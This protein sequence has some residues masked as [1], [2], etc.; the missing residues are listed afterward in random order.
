MSMEQFEQKKAFV[1]RELSRCVTAV[2]GNVSKLEYQFTDD[3]QESVI[4]RFSNG[5]IKTVDVTGDSLYSVMF[6]VVEALAEV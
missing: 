2:D 3:G 4:I 6:N 5:Y 1:T